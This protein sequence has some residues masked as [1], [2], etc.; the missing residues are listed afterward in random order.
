[1]LRQAAPLGVLA[2]GQTL[3]LISGGIDLSVGMLI[4]LVVPLGALVMGGSDGA[5]LPAIL[6]MLGVGAAVGTLNGLLVAFVGVHPFVLTF[7][8]MALLQGL[9]FA[10]TDY[11]T[12]GQISPAF[13]GFF[14]RVAGLPTSVWILFALA[15]VT[16]LVLK[17]TRFG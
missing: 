10:L 4:G 5:I 11:R 14:T 13:G 8:M 15:L 9:T 2:I 16:G 17:Y 3:V 6:A 12:V 1:V 7:G